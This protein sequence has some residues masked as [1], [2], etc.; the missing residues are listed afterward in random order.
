MR[1]TP[2]EAGWYWR[3]TVDPNWDAVLNRRPR[4]HTRPTIVWIDCTVDTSEPY[5]LEH[6]WAGPIPEPEEARGGREY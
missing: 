3:R 2:N 1:D 4:L 6:E 5:R